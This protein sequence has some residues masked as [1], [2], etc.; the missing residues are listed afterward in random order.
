M[1]FIIGPLEAILFLITLLIV[2]APVIFIVFIVV[3]LSSRSKKTNK[4]AID[5]A[6]ERYAK[7]EIS[8]DEFE[9]IKS[10]L[11]EQ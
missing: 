10:N 2:I 7:G 11:A 9:E 6:K 1:P 4:S 5:L 3:W 8:K